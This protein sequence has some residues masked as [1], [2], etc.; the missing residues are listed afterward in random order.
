ML[1][2]KINKS[3]ITHVGYDNN[4]LTVTMNSGKRYRYHDVP[5]LHYRAIIVSKRPGEYYGENIRGKFF[6]EKLNPNQA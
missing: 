6:S 3:F 4:K 5:M 2:Q 1:S